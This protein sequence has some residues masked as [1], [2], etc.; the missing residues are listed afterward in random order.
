MSSLGLEPNMIICWIDLT[1][2]ILNGNLGATERLAYRLGL[3]QKLMVTLSIAREI[4]SSRYVISGPSIGWR[5]LVPS[6]AYL[7]IAQS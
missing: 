6:A 2:G 4:F 7:F 5:D 3:S 1:K